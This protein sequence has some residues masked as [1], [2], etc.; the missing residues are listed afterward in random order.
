MKETTI[1]WSEQFQSEEEGPQRERIQQEVES[2][3][4]DELSR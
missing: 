2:W 4:M 1:I 3:L